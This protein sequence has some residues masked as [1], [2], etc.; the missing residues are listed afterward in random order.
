[1]ITLTNIHKTYPARGGGAS[2]H[3]LADIDLSIGR[4]EVF[5]IIGRSGAGKSTLLRTVNLLES[6][7]SG[8]VTLQRTTPRNGMA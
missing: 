2:V 1:M 3:A 7:S 5:G 4:G 6:P 8:S